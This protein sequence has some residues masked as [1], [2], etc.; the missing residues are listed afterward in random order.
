MDTVTSGYSATPQARKLGI[1]PGMRVSFSAVPEGWRLSDPPAV[2]VIEVG[3]VDVLVWFVRT[4]AELAEAGTAARRIFPD[5]ALWVAWPRRAAGHT[6]D[7]TENAIR[8]AVLPLG[9][10]DVKVA[11]IDEDWSGLK[12]VWRTGNRG[13][14]SKV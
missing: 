11:A 3:S 4:A 9:L 2:E 8:E 6:S 5:G 12:V 13:R 10:V 7:V 14:R 1:K